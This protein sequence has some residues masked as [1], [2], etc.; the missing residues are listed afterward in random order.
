MFLLPNL[1]DHTEARAV[2]QWASPEW[3]RLFCST[4]AKPETPLPATKPPS[5]ACDELASVTPARGCTSAAKGHRIGLAVPNSQ[6]MTTRPGDRLFRGRGSTRAVKLCSPGPE[7]SPPRSSPT[8]EPAVSRIGGFTGGCADFFFSSRGLD[9]V[10]R[11]SGDVHENRQ[12]GLTLT[13][14]ADLESARGFN[15]TVHP[16]FLVSRE[17]ILCAACTLHSG[18]ILKTRWQCAVAHS[19][20][21]CYRATA[22]TAHS[23]HGGKGKVISWCCCNPLPLFSPR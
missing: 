10:A 6:L 21:C 18:R 19:C 12:A 20:A 8:K 17:P 5:E 14:A 7:Y 15:S 13:A 3:R 16:W 4:L 11:A 22:T 2:C 9:S 23:R 1:C